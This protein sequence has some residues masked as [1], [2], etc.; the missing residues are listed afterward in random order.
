ML[1][2]RSNLYNLIRFH[3][4]NKFFSYDKVQIASSILANS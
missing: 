3:C 1:K 2:V 4:K